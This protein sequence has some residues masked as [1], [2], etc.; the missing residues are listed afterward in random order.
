MEMR[1]S[2]DQNCHQISWYMVRA[3]LLPDWI[4]S[5]LWPL[6]ARDQRFLCCC[7][8][9]NGVKISRLRNSLEKVMW[10]WYLRREDT[11]MKSKR[12]LEVSA[13]CIR[14]PFLDGNWQSNMYIIHSCLRKGVNNS[15]CMGHYITMQCMHYLTV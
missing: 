5:F 4:L 12:I 8:C 6:E 11:R 14:F 1:F 3:R 9:Q 15:W 13:T 2:K 7:F 10:P